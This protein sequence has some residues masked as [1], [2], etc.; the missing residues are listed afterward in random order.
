MI[1]QSRQKQKLIILSRIL[2][3]ETDETHPLSVSELI[4]KLALNDIKAERKT[5]YD[6]IA[7][8]AETGMDIV[9]DKRGH[10]NV[11]YVGSRLFQDE[12]LLV[13]A[14][15]VAS[16]KFLTVKKSNELIKKLQSLT[17]KYS[18]TKLKRT[19]YV[20]NRAKTFNESIYYTI[21]SIHEAMYMDKDISFKYFE[22]D[23]E[24]KKRFR[25]NGMEYKVSPYY[26]IW[27]NDCYYLV[28]YSKRH[29]NIS[30]Y[31]V[32]RMNDV[33]VTKSPRH[34]LTVDEENIAKQLRATYNMYGGRSEIVTLQMDAKL[35]NVLIDKYGEGV[36][37]N[38]LD[39]KHFTVRLDVQISPTFWGWLFQFGTQ[40]KIIAP[41]SVVEEAK[42]ELAKIS[43]MYT[44]TDEN[45]DLTDFEF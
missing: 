30:R 34:Q 37:I 25:Y 6:D 9:V 11:Y 19:I 17:S 16:S 4:A 29:S 27:E 15:A 12:E 36:R 43:K 10:S 39:D 31:R 24:K 38:P 41:K 44:Q 26:L 5:I 42:C 45:L 18:A 7:T 28:C 35:L 2:M 8:L 3:N 40:A 14:D 20:G 13:L 22:Y 23:L 33:T 32:D 1:S 21:N